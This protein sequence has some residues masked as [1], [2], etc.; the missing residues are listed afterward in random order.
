M[1]D[2]ARIIYFEEAH[3]EKA[4]VMFAFSVLMLVSAG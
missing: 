2:Y 4:C 1:C 3:T